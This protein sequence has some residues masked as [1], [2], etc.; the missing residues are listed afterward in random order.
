MKKLQEATAALYET[1]NTL[2]D[3]SDE[4]M[5]SAKQTLRAAEKCNEERNSNGEADEFI[6]ELLSDKFNVNYTDYKTYY[7]EVTG[8]ISDN[9]QNALTL[10]FVEDVIAFADDIKNLLED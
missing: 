4:E 7:P 9:C 8:D 3:L 5:F 2:S 1:Y 6:T 10:Y